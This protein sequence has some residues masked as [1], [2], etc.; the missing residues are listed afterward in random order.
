MKKRNPENLTSRTL[1]HNS[2]FR[3]DRSL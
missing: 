3:K 1:V 2:T